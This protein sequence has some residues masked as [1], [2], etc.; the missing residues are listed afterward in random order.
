MQMY[1]PLAYWNCFSRPM[2]ENDYVP[3][4]YLYL[5]YAIFYH[6]SYQFR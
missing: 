5:M 2:G 3:K 6:T 4:V 1:D